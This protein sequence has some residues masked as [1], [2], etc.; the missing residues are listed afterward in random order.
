MAPEVHKE[1]ANYVAKEH[2]QMI[3]GVGTVIDE[4]TAALYLAYGTNFVV[5]P[6][7]NEALARLCNRRKVA[8]M[9]GC[10]SASE[11]SNAEELGVEIVKVFPGDS[12]G[13][14]AF[15]KAMLGPSPWTRI[16]PTGGVDA[17]EESI[18]AW[19][20]AGVAAVGIGTNLM[21]K[22][23]IA[24]KDWDA[25]AGQVRQVLDWIKA[26]RGEAV[27][28]GVEHVGLYPTP[29][30]NGQ[31]IAQWYGDRFGFRVAE[32]SS[33]IFVSGQGS[34]RIE[35]MKETLTDRCHVAVRVSNFEKAVANLQAQGVELAEPKIGA[36]FKAVFLK[37]TDPAG[38][39]V[40]LLWTA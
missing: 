18:R 38:N 12:V 14:P 28:L 3:L 23:W 21:R 39:L 36:G 30:A 37:E 11:I 32:G 10:G 9:P 6:V 29:A 17:S 4:P 22:E 35:V 24:A 19:F 34:G 33:S 27:F 8:Y 5:G 31:A 26:A 2:P 7:L 20:K 40:H 13:G 16:M 1:L 25:I 15:V